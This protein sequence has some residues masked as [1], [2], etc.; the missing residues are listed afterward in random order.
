MVDEDINGPLNALPGCNPINE[1]DPPSPNCKGAAEFGIVYN[2]IFTD[3][4]ES[5]K[6]AYL[7]CSADPVQRTLEKKVAASNDMTVEKCVE[8]CK[9]RHYIYA[10]L[11][12]SSECFCGNK[13]DPV[14]IPKPDSVGNCDMRC[15]GNKTQK[16]GDGGRLSLYKRCKSNKKCKNVE[17]ELPGAPGARVKRDYELEMFDEDLNSTTN[18]T[19][20]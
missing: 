9:K 15:S 11:E 14:G 5:H 3:V 2:D 16:C 1:N 6:Y 17:Y 8:L 19:V 4:T 12:Y 10:G 18:G 13:L 20:Y 7:G